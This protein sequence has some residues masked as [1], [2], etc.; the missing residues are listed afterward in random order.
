M[1]NI[2]V[3]SK[4]TPRK[5][6][7][8]NGGGRGGNNHSLAKHREWDGEGGEG[9]RQT[10]KTG[11]GKEPA[12]CAQGQDVHALC[13]TWAEVGGRQTIDAG[14]RAQRPLWT[15]PRAMTALF[16][17]G[18]PKVTTTG[19]TTLQCFACSRTGGTFNARCTMT[20]QGW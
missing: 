16:V 20:R 9:D 8:R 19:M 4:E 1:A 10:N 2:N 12:P 18:P 13:W 17:A 5:W 11:P 15:P 7:G 3:Y 14:S 6:K